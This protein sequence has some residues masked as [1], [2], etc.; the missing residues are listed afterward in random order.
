GRLERLSDHVDDEIAAGLYDGMALSITVKGETVL[1]H[2]GGFADRSANI[3]LEDRHVFSVMSLTK[4]M[5][6]LAIFQAVER[7]AVSLTTRVCE[8]IPEFAQNGKQRITIAQLL[9]HTGGMPFTLPGLRPEDEGD[10]D[11]TVAAAC[12]IAPVNR[13]GDVVSYSAQVSY[14]VLGGIIQKLDPA[15]RRYADIIAEDIFEPL[16]MMDSSI[17][18][19]SDLADRRVPVVPCKETEINFRLAARDRRLGAGSQLPGGGAFSTL[20][21]IHRFAMMLANGGRLGGAVIVSPASLALATRNHT[22]DRPNNTLAAQMELR[23]WEPFPANLGLGF[24]IRGC[25]L[26][27][28]PFGQLASPETFG[29]IGAGSMVM[30]IDP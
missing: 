23:G 7:G 26:H 18:I 1:R 13:P 14:D 12:R 30:G 29:G 21:D 2:V 8:V 6:A 11:A 19:R 28:T 20:A 4:P 15:G 16:G 25:G 10:L 5:T 27:P 3:P 24:F 22:G 17:G 9:S